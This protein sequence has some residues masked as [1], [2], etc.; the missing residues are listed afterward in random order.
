MDK[1]VEELKVRAVWGPWDSVAAIFR[2]YEW[3]KSGEQGR[4]TAH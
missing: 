2:Q 4:R 3:S 1:R